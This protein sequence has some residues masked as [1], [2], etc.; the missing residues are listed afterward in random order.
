MLRKYTCLCEDRC[1]GKL[2]LC[3]LCLQGLGS[4]RPVYLCLAAVVAAAEAFLW[5]FAPPALALA[6]ILVAFTEDLPL[7]LVALG[8]FLWALAWGLLI[9]WCF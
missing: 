4:N 7:D 8:A 5:A 9:L 6:L 1:G 2:S 3:L